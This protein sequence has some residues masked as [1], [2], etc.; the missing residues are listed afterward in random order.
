MLAKMNNQKQK[1]MVVQAS[2]KLSNLQLELLKLYGSG[3]SEEDLLEIKRF[4]A[5]YFMKKA[6]AEADKVW[7]EKGYTNEL[8]DEWLHTKRSQ[9]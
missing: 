3:V 6:V 8:M 1:D 9:L 5:K 2:Q 7:D 4:L